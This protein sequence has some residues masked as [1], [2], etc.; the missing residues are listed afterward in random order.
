MTWS[1]FWS[2]GTDVLGKLVALLGGVGAVAAACFGLFKWLGERW[3]ESKF[4]TR[5]EAFKHEQQKELEELRF[6][7][8]S[9]F[10][11]TI[12]LHQREFEVLPEAWSRLVVAH[13]AVEHLIYGLRSFPDIDAMEPD[14]LEEFLSETNLSAHQKDELKNANPK[15]AYYRKFIEEEII[16][17]CRNN[18]M[19]FNNYLGQ[20]GIFLHPEINVK[21]HG[22]NGLIRAAY[23]EHDVNFR[24]GPPRERA[25]A[26]RFQTESKH[27]LD[28]LQTDVRSRM[29]NTESPSNT[30]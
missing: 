11:R 1:E 22:L 3:L 19:E 2:T 8:N 21:F 5:L 6:R 24:T 13:G 17:D 18:L 29:W 7:I 4:Q 10:D 28:D 25:A 16:S 27:L 14:R 20:H 23:S 26:Q 9:L 15:L 30:K 12:K